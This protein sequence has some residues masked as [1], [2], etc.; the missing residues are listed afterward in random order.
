MRHWVNIINE[1][2]KNP[3]GKNGPLIRF[4]HRIQPNIIA[5]R[6]I[7][8]PHLLLQVPKDFI[9]GLGWLLQHSCNLGFRQSSIL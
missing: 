1:F 7:R 2:Q 5:A 6:H 9:C 3:Y 4:I 8:N